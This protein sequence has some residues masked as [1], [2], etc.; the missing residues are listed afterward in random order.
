MHFPLLPPPKVPSAKD[1]AFS[2][3]LR[4]R[5]TCKR[6]LRFGHF[7]ALEFNLILVQKLTASFCLP[8]LDCKQTLITL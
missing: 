4:L 7:R 6:G 5:F 1:S 8:F 2:T 3:L